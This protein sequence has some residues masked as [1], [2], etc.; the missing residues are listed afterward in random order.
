MDVS[1]IVEIVDALLGQPISLEE[2]SCFFDD[3]PRENKCD[4]VYP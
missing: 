4:R 2:L 1:S 3:F